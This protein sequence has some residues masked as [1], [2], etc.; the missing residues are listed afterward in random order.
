M[1][2]APRD[3]WTRNGA[4]F[5]GASMLLLAGAAGLVASEG[6]APNDAA[7]GLSV[8]AGV[9]LNRASAAELSDSIVSKLMLI[10]GLDKPFWMGHGFGAA[11]GNFNDSDYTADDDP[12]SMLARPTID[13]VM[14]W[15]P[16]FYEDLSAV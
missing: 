7:I 14:A 15:S 2:V 9:D 10:R 4:R 3:D 8:R 12:E 16:S 6:R 1:S 11:L 5:V 13:Q